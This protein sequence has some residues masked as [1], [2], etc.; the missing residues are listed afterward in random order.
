MSV[1]RWVE[2]LFGHRNDRGQ[3]LN[4][5]YEQAR[6][7]FQQRL[8]EYDRH[9]IASSAKHGGLLIGEGTSSSGDV[10][11]VLLEAGRYAAN[12]IALG[13][14][15]VG[16]TS[17][18]LGRLEEK[19]KEAVTHAA[20]QKTE[21]VPRCFIGAID[22][23]DDFHRL[24]LQVIATLHT[25][26]GTKAAE[27]LC[28]QVVSIDPAASELPPLNVC[29]LLPGVTA[30]FQAYEVALVLNRLLLNEITS[31]GEHLLRNLLIL[32]IHS[33]LS[34]A[35]AVL[36]LEDE[37]LRNV[38]VSCCPNESV[39][40]F[41]LR[42]YPSWPEVSK[43]ALVN[44][45]AALLLSVAM[46]LMLGSD[47]LLDLRTIFEQGRP[48]FIRL[49]RGLSVPDEQLSVLGSLLLQQILYATYSRRSHTPYLLQID[50]FIHLLQSPALIERFSTAL[51]TVRSYGLNLC[52]SF[53]NASQIPAGLRETMIANSDLVALF[54]TNA[55]SAAGFGKFLPTIDLEAEELRWR[56][57]D[58]ALAP[59][60]QDIHAIE[61]LP[62]RHFFWFDRRS[63]KTSLLLKTPE[64]V[65]PHRRL[66]ISETEMEDMVNAMSWGGG[67]TVPRTKLQEQIRRRH[68]RLREMLNPKIEVLPMESS[69]PTR[70]QQTKK[71]GP[72]LG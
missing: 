65:P 63:M 69:R 25:T 48:L 12:W 71:S 30:E 28:S 24:L 34:L 16:K 53:H 55:E 59:V 62:D 8:S 6:Q 21:D 49:G 35:E 18:M 52:L 68:D 44:K 11:P 57:G 5:V 38:L 45:L 22:C 13:A 39:K 61:R 7:P 46:R 70:K 37:L 27:A 72:Q 1:Y 56:K 33:K 10:V 60:R 20:F 31:L 42:T 17:W 51:T 36:V 64:F 54:R 67:V 40:E 47:E 14:T 50:E 2:T 58:S 3:S 19:I 29:H 43:R 66:G 41:F 9:L 4:L 23:K 32:L 26:I 15:G